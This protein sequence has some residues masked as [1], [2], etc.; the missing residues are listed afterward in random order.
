VNPAKLVEA[1]QRWQRL[2]TQA[3]RGEAE[4]REALRELGREIEYALVDAVRERTRNETEGKG[5]PWK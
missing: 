3:T 1:L 2:H 4:G 5:A